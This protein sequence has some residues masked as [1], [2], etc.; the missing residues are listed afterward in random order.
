MNTT[1]KLFINVFCSEI[2]FIFLSLIY[3]FFEFITHF[4]MYFSLREFVIREEN[5][6]EICEITRGV[7][8]YEE[9]GSEN[10]PKS[11]ISYLNSP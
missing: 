4:S 2:N 9:G 6:L 5:S 1:R 8:K 3:I 11:V 7:A 10:P